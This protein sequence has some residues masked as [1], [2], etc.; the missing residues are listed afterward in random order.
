MTLGFDPAK[1]S[2]VGTFIGSMM[3]NIWMYHGIVDA[4]QKRLP[5][6][7]EGPR[8]D[9]SG[10]CNYR[11]TIEFIDQDSWL[12]TSEMQNDDGQWGQFMCG[13]HTRA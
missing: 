7:T 11:D 10:M 9:G 3:T 1:N 4:S 8:F 5:L 2:Y 6:D 13:K 12:F